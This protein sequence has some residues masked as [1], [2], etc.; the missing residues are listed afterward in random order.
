[1]GRAHRIAYRALRPLL[2]S[3]DAERA[4]DLVLSI[5]AGTEYP[6]IGRAV[7]LE[8]VDDPV[9]IAGI[10]FPNRV[11]LAAGLDK[12]ARCLPALASMGFGFIE[13]GS[14]APRGEAWSEP[15]RIHRFPQAQALINR[16]GLHREGLDA[17]CAALARN[18]RPLDRRAPVPVRLGINLA[19]NSATLAADSLRDY[20]TGLRA[21]L[22]WADYFTI[23]VSNPNASNRHVPATRPALD[24][25]LAAINRIRTEMGDKS[26]KTPPVFLKISPDLEASTWS[27][28]C[29]ALYAQRDKIGA[30]ALC[31]GLIV[32]NTSLRR[33]AVQGLAHAELRGGLSGKP[34]SGRVN[35]LVSEIR[36]HL[37]KEFPI[38]GVG[39]IMSGADA[40]ERIEAGADLV[41]LYTGLIYR[42][43]DLVREVATALRP[44]P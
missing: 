19:C 41:Q 28:L 22:R 2:F 5:L 11:G 43:P 14:V 29:D 16:V 1:M 7:A 27:L 15:P 37:G 38:I 44:S 21:T 20:A 18:S 35:Q 8:R 17:L 26:G 42:G 10:V 31:W 40:R 30:N 23:N 6:L 39:G 34:L 36:T 25:W 9:E 4:H 3:L 32:S 12:E 13:V 24:Q 33:E